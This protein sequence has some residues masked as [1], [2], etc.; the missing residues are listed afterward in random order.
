[1][2]T[3][4]DVVSQLKNNKEST[5]STNNNVDKTTSAVSKLTDDVNGF[6][7]TFLNIK[8][9]ERLNTG[10]SLEASRESGSTG[11]FGS[12]VGAAA[13]GI[14]SG[15]GSALGGLGS[16]FS[17]AGMGVGAAGLGIGALLA[18]GGYFLK[19]LESFDGKKVKENVLELFAISDAFS[20]G[21]L[22][23]FA[24]GGLFGSAMLGIGIGLA[25]FGVGSAAVGLADALNNFFGVQ[26]WAQ[27][28][29]DN[30]ITLLSIADGVGGNLSFFAEAGIFMGAMTGLGL[31]LAVFGAGSAIAGIGEA[32]SRF[33]S[34]EDWAQ[35]IKNNVITL[36]SIS[37]DL[38]GAGAFIGKSAT[39]FAAMFGIA[40][41]LALFGV[42]STINGLSE[43]ITRDD[44][45]NKIK[46]DVMTLMSIEDDLGG[47]AA[48]FGEAGT[49]LAAMT[50]IAAGLAV[51][52]YGSGIVG[53]S[54]LISKNDWATKIK[55]DVLALLSIA[56]SLPGD[57]TFMGESGKFFLAMSGIA[58]GLAVF[59]AG[60]FVGTMANAVT[61]VLSF[62]IGAENPF[63]QLM[64]LA[65]NADELSLG[66]TALEKITKALD[67]FAGI[68]ISSM[69][70][71]FE[72]LA[73]DLG[74]A[75]PFLDALANGGDVEGSA[76]WFGSNINFP[77]GILD[78]S[79]RIDEMAAAIAK[80]NYILGQTTEYPMDVVPQ[81]RSS[82]SNLQ[83]EQNL[84]TSSQRNAL[85]GGVVAN[86]GNTNIKQGDNTTINY[87]QPNA[88]SAHDPR[89]DLSRLYVLGYGSRG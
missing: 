32:I 18:G 45:A 62:F 87:V 44:W 67:T 71:D 6:F 83:Q 60:Q 64:R 24:T 69:N 66:A 85:S 14:G 39:F 82:G 48:I 2:A 15:V 59:A 80:V 55:S 13:S 78:P 79:L 89:T 29:K 22:E 57:D 12:G 35:T 34:G 3:L 63:D 5:D 20:G 7:T 19:A 37:D 50:G 10:D 86:S 4:K 53:L 47:K 51:F 41:G 49:F 72:Q 16:L 81:P 77:K 52:G 56:D 9:T 43:L 21:M 28:V 65:D 17:G 33:T 58:A 27:S 26:D 11:G 36:M 30:V 61:S 46:S 68:K 8:K 40:T 73:L 25:A 38:G 31:G 76:G 23:F 54:E 70:L 42:G 75:V 1:M 84:L 88:P 74:K